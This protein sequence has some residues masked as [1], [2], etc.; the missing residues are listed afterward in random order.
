MDNNAWVG[1]LAII[2]GL[3]IV[4]EGLGI[5]KIKGRRRKKKPSIIRSFLGSTFIVFGFYIMRGE[6]SQALQYVDIMEMF[7]K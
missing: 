1:L 3:L 6:I 5:I 4:L 2:F 7:V